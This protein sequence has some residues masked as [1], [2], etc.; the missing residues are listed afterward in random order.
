M[1]P[2]LFKGL[3][4]F[5]FMNLILAASTAAASAITLFILCIDIEYQPLLIIFLI[6]FASY[7]FNRYTDKEDRINHPKRADY[8]QR[9]GKTLISAAVVSYILALIVA[10]QANTITFVIT[11]VPGVAI[12]LYSIKWIPNKLRGMLGGSRIKEFYLIKNIFVAAIWSFGVVFLPL[13]YF[14]EEVSLT[15]LF[16]WL[17]F[18]GRFV[19]NTIMFDLKDIEGDPKFNI[20]SLPVKIGWNNSLIA[21]NVLNLLLYAIIG[22]ATVFENLPFMLFVVISLATIYSRWYLDF[23]SKNR[24]HIHVICDVLVDAEYIVTA[25]L[26]ALFIFV[27]TSLTSQTDYTLLLGCGSR[28]LIV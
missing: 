6:T 14:K 8:I 18:L 4:K 5:A 23:A 16:L 12:S 25:S 11:L 24:P 9:H 3:Q 17:F 19:I 10:W 21:L 2:D 13:S 28:G 27:L 1:K 15:A 22:L 7:T 26:L 20:K